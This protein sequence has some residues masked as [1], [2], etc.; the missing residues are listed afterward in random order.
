MESIERFAKEVMPEF[1]E[2]HETQHK[3]WRERRLEGV[4][5]PIKS[6]I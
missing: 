3:Q 6:S 5:F 4:E 1:R 2:R